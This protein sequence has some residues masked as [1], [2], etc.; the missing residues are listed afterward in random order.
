MTFVTLQRR[1]GHA[2]FEILCALRSTEDSFANIMAES[3]LRYLPLRM[4]PD[5][6]ATLRYALLASPARFR[7]TIV[8]SFF[9][10]KIK[11]DA[12]T[13]QRTGGLVAPDFSSGGIRRRS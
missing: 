2:E 12:K 5:V 11:F 3:M 4:T 9:V 7:A 1:S 10:H 13:L 6:E 8:N